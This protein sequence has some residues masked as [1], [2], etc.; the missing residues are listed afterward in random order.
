VDIISRKSS[1]VGKCGS[2]FR[3]MSQKFTLHR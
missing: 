3:I 1:S 2:F